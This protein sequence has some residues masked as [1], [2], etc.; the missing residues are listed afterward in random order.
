MITCSLPSIGTQW[1]ATP[2]SGGAWRLVTSIQW[3]S[4]T[5]GSPPLPGFAS[6]VGF[7]W[8]AAASYR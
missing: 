6:L 4:L 8:R 2:G 1:S 5:S 3:P 7:T